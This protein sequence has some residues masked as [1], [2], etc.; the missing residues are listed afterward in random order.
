MDC[1]NHTKLKAYLTPLG[2]WALSFGCSVGWGSFVMPGTT[3]LPIAGPVGTALGLAV[4]AIVMLIIG[5]NYYYLMNRYPDAG[6]IVSYTR[7]TFGYDH[8]FLS[9]WFAVLA[10]IVIVWANLTAVALIARNMLGSVFQF[11]F[12]YQL[13][14]Y[15]I[16]FGEVVTAI[17]ALALCGVFCLLRKRLAA[18]VQILMALILFFGIVTCFTVA[19]VK[20]GGVSFQPAFSQSSESDS[21]VQIFS[22]VALAPWAYVGFESI[23]H[24]A[25]EFQFDKKKNFPI[26]LIALFTAGLAYILLSLLATTARPEGYADWAAYIANLS[27]LDGVESLPT[28]YATRKAMGGAGMIVLGVTLIGGIVTGIIGN[29]IAASRVLYA[30]AKEDILPLW[31]RKLSSDGNPRNATFFVLAVSAIIP[32]FGRTAISWIVDVTTVGATIIY[33]YASAAAFK[34]ARLSRDRK[35]AVWG[36]LG[37]IISIGFA[38]YFLIPN[39]SSVSTLGTESYL[40]LTVWSILG[41]IFFR[42]VFGRDKKHRF[43]KS[44]VVWIVLLFLILFTSV[45]WMEQANE[46]AIDSATANISAKYSDDLERLNVSQPDAQ[47]EEISTYVNSQMLTLNHTLTRNNFI[48]ILL[49]M[50]SIGL[51][52]TVYTL[53]NKR[54]REFDRIQLLAYKDTMTGVGN[55]HSYKTEE[56][57]LNQRIKDGGAEDFAIAVCDLNGLKVINDTL[58][59]SAGDEYI[60]EACLIICDLFAHSPVYRVGGDEFVVILRGRDYEN[61][62]ELLQQLHDISRENQTERRAVIAAG[63]S[64]FCPEK[65]KAVNDVFIRA[66]VAMYRDKKSLKNT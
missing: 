66:D 29:T 56:S 50:I 60:K 8:S 3:F 6:G 4:G 30:M 23:S 36:L 52:F 35:S 16:Y 45:V 39:I 54:Q 37:V 47:Q 34:E 21:L 5:R 59:H 15:D 10:Y 9:G 57:E 22:I 24:S 17:G 25:E 26:I 20:N 2:V 43:G 64:V 11:G 33:F 18:W 53:M 51:L 42:T 62:E 63:V 31:F 32:F 40:I 41:L 13:A 38:L 27:G 49:I 65:D 48:R 28:F 12:H 58:G 61:R 14:G 19:A 55:K 7:N 1:N 44:I 46:S